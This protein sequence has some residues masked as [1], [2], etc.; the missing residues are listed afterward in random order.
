MQAK[1]LILPL[2][3][4]T[5][6]FATA[7]NK[8]AETPPAD[9]AATDTAPMTDATTP[10]ADSAMPADSMSTTPA[11]G[12]MPAA[13][14]PADGAMA[15]TTMAYGDLD[16]NADGGISSDEAAADSMLSQHF[17]TADADGDGKVTQAEFDKH[18]AD[19]ASKPAM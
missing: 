2:A 1:T 17:S 16:K 10:P 6:L 9:P 11:D 12:S 19:M 7:C 13:T 18:N 15:P 14:P 3:L 4:A 8:D 5:A